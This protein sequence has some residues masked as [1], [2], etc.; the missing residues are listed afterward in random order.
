MKEGFP[1]APPAGHNKKGWYAHTP[2]HVY[3]R[4]RVE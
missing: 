3:R 4:Q 2:L 1:L